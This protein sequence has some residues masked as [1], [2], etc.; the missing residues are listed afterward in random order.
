LG[1]GGFCVLEEEDDIGKVARIVN[2][3]NLTGGK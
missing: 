2:V 3:K 1:A